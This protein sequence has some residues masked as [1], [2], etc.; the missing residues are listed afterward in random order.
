M[1]DA[2]KLSGHTGRGLAHVISKRK[3]MYLPVESDC[4]CRQGFCNPNDVV[5]SLE[6]G[7]S[8]QSLCLPDSVIYR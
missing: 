2:L 7:R 1:A 6:Y 8:C 3:R 5:H 4:R